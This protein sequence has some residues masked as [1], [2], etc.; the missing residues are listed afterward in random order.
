MGQPGRSSV[1]VQQCNRTSAN[2]TETRILGNRASP[3]PSGDTLRLPQ[4][5]VSGQRRGRDHCYLNC[6]TPGQTTSA[7]GPLGSLAQHAALHLWSPSTHPWASAP[8]LLV[9]S[10]V[11]A[12]T[13]PCNNKTVAQP[14]QGPSACKGDPTAAAPLAWCSP[15]S[16]ATKITS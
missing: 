1:T 13:S 6:E 7:R 9:S 16:P 2:S 8:F 3:P 4:L 5:Q 12:F 15:G 10:R 11:E 14:V